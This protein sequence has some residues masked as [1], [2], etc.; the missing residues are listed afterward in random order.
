MLI[1][2]IA[3]FALLACA[4]VAAVVVVLRSAH[5]ESAAALHELA[6]LCGNSAA[7]RA[8]LASLVAKLD[9]LSECSQYDIERR[10]AEDACAYA[11]QQRHQFEVK[12]GATKW[13]WQDK[14]DSARDYA[15]MHLGHARADAVNAQIEAVLGAQRS[16]K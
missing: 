15:K 6:F 11:E 4:N 13:T 10:V 14:R 5:A 9:A 12:R 2:M 8:N 1:A 16:G 3:V 7:D